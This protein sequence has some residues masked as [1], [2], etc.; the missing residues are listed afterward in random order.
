MS[1]A[2]ALVAVSILVAVSLLATGG[3]AGPEKIAFPAGWQKFVLYN[4]VDRYDNKQYR[5][6]YAS[7]QEAVDAA[8]AG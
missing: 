4:V 7:S 3:S 6:L 1:R 8:K 5:E 2:V